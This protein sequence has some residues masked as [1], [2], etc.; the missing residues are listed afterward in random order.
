[1]VIGIGRRGSEGDGIAEWADVI[2]EIDG[3]G[4]K[5]V[6]G[7]GAEETEC[8]VCDAAVDAEVKGPVQIDLRGEV[9][10]ASCAGIQE[11]LA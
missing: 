8:G 9:R 7:V 3:A 11:M 10:A 5:T 1:V 2:A 4:G 6:S